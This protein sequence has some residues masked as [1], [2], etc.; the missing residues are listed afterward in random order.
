MEDEFM[1]YYFSC[2]RKYAQFHGRARRKE[3]WW[4]TIINAIVMGILATFS[5]MGAAYVGMAE[6][7]ANGEM[8]VIPMG[9]GVGMWVLVI[10]DLAVLLPMLAVAVRR[11]HDT[12]RTGW[13]LFINLVPV[14]GGI[15]FFVL[16]L[17]DSVPGENRFGPNPKEIPTPD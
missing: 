6:A 15:W 7:L 16:T 4:F 12:S 5:G 3:Y 14:I 2:F 11:L 13:W 8:P 10:Y 17:L 1:N 9:S